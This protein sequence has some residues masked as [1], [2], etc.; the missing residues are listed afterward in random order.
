MT[1]AITS[2]SQIARFLDS[3]VDDEVRTTML[4]GQVAEKSAMVSIQQKLLSPLMPDIGRQVD[5]TA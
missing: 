4:K 1:A 2:T 3:V 5:I